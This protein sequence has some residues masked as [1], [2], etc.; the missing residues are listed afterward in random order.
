MGYP[1]DRA[2]ESSIPAAC[3]NIFSVRF[4]LTSEK[5]RSVTLLLG[6]GGTPI[7]AV[8]REILKCNFS[9]KGVNEKKIK[10]HSKRETK[11]RQKNAIILGK[12][13][14]R[15]YLHQ[16]GGARR[17]DIFQFNLYFKVIRR[18]ALNKKVWNKGIFGSFLREIVLNVEWLTSSLIWLRSEDL[19]KWFQ[20]IVYQLQ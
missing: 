3:R 17:V 13:N 2:S 15:H 9:W 5:T 19:H 4:H 1:P 11:K 8:D 7:K 10:T 18:L 12:N 20:N 16:C 6:L 14:L